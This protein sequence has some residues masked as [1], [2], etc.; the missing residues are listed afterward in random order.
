MNKVWLLAYVQIVLGF[1]FSPVFHIYPLFI[2]QMKK[3]ESATASFK[4]Y[5]EVSV[6]ICLPIRLFVGLCI[7]SFVIWFLYK[8]FPKYGPNF[9]KLW[10]MHICMTKAKFEKCMINT[11][12]KDAEL[13]IGWWFWCR[14]IH[15]SFNQ[16]FCVLYIYITY[17][18]DMGIIKFGNVC[19]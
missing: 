1:S 17:P 16:L 12:S 10:Q 13:L 15:R 6:L 4:I 7:C 14:T 19:I 5:S 8:S 3:I 2:N 18:V 11:Y 9:T